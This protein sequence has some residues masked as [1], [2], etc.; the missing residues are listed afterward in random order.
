MEAIL[1]NLPLV[2]YPFPCFDPQLK[3]TFENQFKRNEN[4]KNCE[5]SNYVLNSYSTQ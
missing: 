2:I 4:I 3:L 1:N 5:P